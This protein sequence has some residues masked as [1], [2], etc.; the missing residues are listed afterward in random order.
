MRVLLVGGK[1][2]PM[3]LLRSVMH[4]AGIT[5]VTHVEDSRRALELLTMDAFSAV[6]FEDGVAACDGLPFA[7]AARRKES[8]VNPMLP[9]FLLQER[10]RRRDV[11]KARDAGATDVLTVPMSPAT[12]MTKLKTAIQTPRPFIVAP[13]FFGPDRRGV[14]GAF[15][16]KERRVRQPRK[17][18]VNLT[19]I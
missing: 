12:L 7:I 1:S 14:R 2:H 16:G 19:H 17:T 8:M 11:E 10:A 6:F 5:Q 4:I 18:R 13:E 9:L 15:Y 3:L